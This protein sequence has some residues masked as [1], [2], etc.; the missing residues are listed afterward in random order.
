MRVALGLLLGFKI[1]VLDLEFLTLFGLCAC[2][3]R[4]KGFLLVAVAVL[5]L[6][7]LEVLLEMALDYVIGHCCV[8][9]L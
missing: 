2:L 8:F 4:G 9:L 7:E 1:V 5:E 3:S 6:L